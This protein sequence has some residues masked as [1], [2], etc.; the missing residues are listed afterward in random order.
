MKTG[1]KQPTEE[2]GRVNQKARQKGTT[3]REEE[4]DNHLVYT[5]RH[6]GGVE[7]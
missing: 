7:T 1:Y 5:N 4:S 6:M 2:T 3:E